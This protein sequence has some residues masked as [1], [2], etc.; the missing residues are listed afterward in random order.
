MVEI[1]YGDQ[2]EITDLAGQTISEAR[3]QFNAD[4]GIPEKAKAKLNGSKVKGSAE[5]DTILNDDDKLSFAV[6][7]SKGAYMVGALL[8]ALTVTGGVFAYGFV[9]ASNTLSVTAAGTDFASVSANTGYEPTWSAYGF[10]KGSVSDGSIFD[11]DPADSYTG[12]LVVTVSISNAD[13]L[14]QVYRMLA[15][16]IMMY[17]ASDNS[18]IIDINESTVGDNDDYVL[19]TLGNG[20]V[21]MF[22]AGTTDSMVVNVKSGFYITH[23]WGGGWGAGFQEPDLFCEVAQR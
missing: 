22:P 2:Y 3:E 16:K 12:D 15:L 11:I 8:L 13:E 1:R 9:N 21:D 20:A 7:R 6:S 23:I 19:L 5:V 4:F 14:V 17:S 18:T 10:F